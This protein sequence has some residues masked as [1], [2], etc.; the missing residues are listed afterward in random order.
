[1][2]GRINGCLN[3]SR[4]LGDFIFK[5]HAG[6]DQSQQMVTCVPDIVKIERNNVDFILM[7]CDGIW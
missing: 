1:M 4:G 3:L 7:G 5:Q 6:L 2:E